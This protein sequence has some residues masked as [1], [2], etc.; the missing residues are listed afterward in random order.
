MNTGLEGTVALVAGG[1]RGI[2]RAV[3][4]AFLQEGAR[5]LLTARTEEPLELAANELAQAFGDDRVLAQPGD[6]ATKEGAEAAVE[7]A[8]AAWDRLDSLVLN[9]GSGTGAAGPTPGREE[10]ERLL[11]ANLWPGVQVAEAA[12]PRMV[13]AG[14]G[15]VVFIGS[16]TGLESVG[17]P[18]PYGAA[19]A[20]LASY[21]GGLARLVGRSGVRVNCVAPG[22]VLHPGGSWEVRLAENRDQVLQ[23]IEREVPLARFGRPDEIANVVVFLCSDA[24]SFVTGA[25]IVA[26]GGQTRA[27]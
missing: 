7:R 4:T 10:W 17:A 15:A 26:D 21:T 1:S 23:M 11:G 19:K 3:A 18:L 22:N 25:V 13:D 9:A 14:R 20:A 5:V 27:S 12:L 16:I 6:L 8:Y 24:A 2:G